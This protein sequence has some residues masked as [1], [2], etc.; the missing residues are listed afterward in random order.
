M[1][2]I[3]PRRFYNEKKVWQLHILRNIS[4]QIQADHLLQLKACGLGVPDPLLYVD[5]EET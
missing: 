2:K 4:V 5:A 1:Y 3:T